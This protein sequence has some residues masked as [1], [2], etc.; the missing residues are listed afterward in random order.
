M[1]DG[2]AGASGGGGGLVRGGRLSA[3]ST[4]SF[5]PTDNAGLVG[6]ICFPLWPLC[7]CDSHPVAAA[8]TGLGRGGGKVELGETEERPGSDGAREEGLDTHKQLPRILLHADGR[9]DWRSFGRF[10]TVLQTAVVV[11][12]S[13]VSGSSN[14]SL[15]SSWLAAAGDPPFPHTHLSPIHEKR[16][17]PLSRRS[18]LAARERRLI[19]CQWL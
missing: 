15:A 11:R 1:R 10:G 13:R 17:T 6:A 8:D 16:S 19:G 12:G 5:V 3:I 4:S 9:A 7:R 2:G 18:R 14:S